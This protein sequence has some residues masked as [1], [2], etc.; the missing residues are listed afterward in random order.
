MEENF[1][2]QWTKGQKLRCVTK[3]NFKSQK[4]FYRIRERRRFIEFMK[5]KAIELGYEIEVKKDTRVVIDLTKERDDD[6]LQPPKQQPL[7]KPLRSKPIWNP[8]PSPIN[9]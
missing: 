9:L 6:E 1:F 2:L 8:P 5:K 7:R 4:P 3:R